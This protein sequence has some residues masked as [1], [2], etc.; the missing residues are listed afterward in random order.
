MKMPFMSR[1]PALRETRP[2][3]TWAVDFMVLDFPSRPYVMLVADVGTRR[4]LSA[5]VSLVVIEDIIAA[6]ERLVRRSGRPEQIWM[7]HSLAYRSLMGDFHPALQAWARRH[8]ISVTAS[9]TPRTT[10]AAE[11][12]LRD[13][14]TFL[15][16]KRFPTLMELGHD[17]ER[18][19]Q[20]YV[21]AADTHIP[22]V[23]Q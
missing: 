8:G 23:T 14:S 5:A 19:R 10:A 20:S 2:S 1:T 13:L 4:P 3:E 22:N 7:D 18:W 6:L 15:R 16:D 11:R 9:P 12:L 17:I 21:A